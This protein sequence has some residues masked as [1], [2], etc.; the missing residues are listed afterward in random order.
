MLA[1][2]RRFGTDSGTAIEKLLE[3]PPAC[4]TLAMQ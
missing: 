3:H 1:L 2:H 4:Q